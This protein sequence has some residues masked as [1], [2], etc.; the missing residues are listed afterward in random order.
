MWTR[1]CNMYFVDEKIEAGH[2]TTPHG[3]LLG[4]W[5]GLPTCR[6]MKPCWCK[7]R[8]VECVQKKRRQHDTKDII[9]YDCT[10]LWDSESSPSWVFVVT[11]LSSRLLLS[12]GHWFT[13]LFSHL[14]T[15]PL[16]LDS[17]PCY[18][19]PTLWSLL[20]AILLTYLFF[21][22]VY[23]PSAPQGTDFACLV[24]RSSLEP[25]R[26]FLAKKLKKKTNKE[27]SK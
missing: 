18:F 1:D 12:I 11:F 20:T 21:L 25:R 26:F 24:Y 14:F 5:Y 15:T 6:K 13:P 7:S 10:V 2:L 3:S 19:S 16:L 22:F 8:D 17:L 9:A 23:W 27:Q 4:M